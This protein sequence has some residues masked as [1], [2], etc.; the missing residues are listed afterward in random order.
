MILM[1]KEF[2][3]VGDSRIRVSG[4]IDPEEPKD[5]AVLL[6]NEHARFRRYVKRPQ[7]AI[8]PPTGIQLQVK[9]RYLGEILVT[10]Y[11]DSHGVSIGIQ[12]LSL[13][14]GV[15]VDLHP[16]RFAAHSVVASR[17]ETDSGPAQPR[18][19]P[20]DLPVT[21]AVGRPSMTDVMDRYDLLPGVYLVDD[22]VIANANSV[23]PVGPGELHGLAGKGVLAQAFASIQNAPN[24]VLREPAEVLLHG[25]LEDDPIWWHAASAAV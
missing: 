11:S 22:P 8:P 20:S 25:G 10:S 17:Y 13:T 5:V 23:Q 14:G 7:P 6:R 9:A 12:K 3:D 2:L 24:L 19:S 18:S 15:A 16:S 4:E 21:S 1:D